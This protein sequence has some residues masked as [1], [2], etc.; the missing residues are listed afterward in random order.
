MNRKTKAVMIAGLMLVAVA[1]VIYVAPALA[2][3]NGTSDQTHD[4]DRDRL[5]DGTCTQLRLRECTANQINARGANSEQQYRYQY[6]LGNQN[7]YP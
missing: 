1:S 2:Y 7:V 6:R 5:R 4:R 3:M